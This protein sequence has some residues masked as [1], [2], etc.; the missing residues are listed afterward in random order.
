MLLNMSH[1]FIHV[2]HV[3]S[4]KETWSSSGGLQLFGPSYLFVTD[5][6]F[7]KTNQKLPEVV[8]YLT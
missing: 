2:L 3:V 8:Q 1:W 5:L 7:L 4:D 6:P